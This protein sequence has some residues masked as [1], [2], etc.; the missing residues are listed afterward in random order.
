[1]SLLC[2]EGIAQEAVNNKINKTKEDIENI[3][4]DSTL[5]VKGSIIAGSE[6]VI[7]PNGD[8]NFDYRLN[9]L[10]NLKY[11][12]IEIPLQLNIS[13]GR[14]I[15]NINGPNFKTPSFKN[16]GVSPTK[17]NLTLHLGN[18]SMSF[19]KYSYEGIRFKGIGIEYE[20]ETFFI[21][22]FKGD[23]TYLNPFENN[24]ISNID[25]PFKRNAFGGQIG[26]TKETIETSLIIFKTE[27]IENIHSNS[28]PAENAVIELNGKINFTESISLQASR[29]LSA[30]STNTRE[31]RESIVTHDT[32][33][34]LFGLFTKRASSQY[35]FANEVNFNYQFDN[36]SISLI[37]LNIDKGYR[38]LGSLLF[39]NNFIS[40]NVAI[41]GNPFD[42]LNFNTIF[43][44]RKSKEIAVEQNNRGQFQINQQINYQA[45]EKLNLS[46]N[47]S[48]LRNTQ[49]VFQRRSSSN[50]IDSI[51]LAQISESIRLGSSYT[52]DKETATILNGNISWQQGLGIQQDSIQ[53]TNSIQNYA[54]NLNLSSTIGNHSLLL[55]S[56]FIT[57][58][59]QTFNNKSILF[60]INDQWNVNDQHDININLGINRFVND[61]QQNNQ[62][63]VSS[64]HEWKIRDNL[65]WSNRFQ[66]NLGENEKLLSINT[67]TFS[68]EFRW[69]FSND[70]ILN[71]TKSEKE[72]NMKE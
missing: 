11:K 66:L 37:H 19:S 46:A 63:A 30:L 16:F 50:V 25:P 5:E 43:G 17:G 64:E 22:A 12:G 57:S 70:N 40:N 27:D 10:L 62:I 9:A 33:Y 69:R 42:K 28:T 21:K 31:P 26:L 59:N 41:S 20:P 1:M 54:F 7:D 65:S 60:N 45:N 23:L 38:S 68:T 47:Y 53:T 34:N 72:N 55:S 58:I 67:I 32:A 35:S 8:N 14:T 18:R 56:N 51:S 4:N 13:N 49:K 29:S 6:Y 24:F 44:I 71:R 48:N 52:F 39:D 36:Y 3:K 2:Y 61:F 15:S